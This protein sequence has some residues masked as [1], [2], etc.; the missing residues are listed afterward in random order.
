MS[1]AISRYKKSRVYSPGGNVRS[2]RR[3]SSGFR[4]ILSLVG[5]VFKISAALVVVVGFSIII[6]LGYREVTTSSYLTL[7]KIEVSG[8][9]Q[10]TYKDVLDAAGV[11]LGDNL[12]GLNISDIR[13]RMMKDPWVNSVI[14][15]REFPDKLCLNL[16]ERQACFWIKKDSRL[17]YADKNGEI[18]APVKTQGFVSLPFLSPRED[19]SGLSRMVKSFQRGDMPFSLQQIAWIGFTPANSVVFELRSRDLR[20]EMNTDNW[21]LSAS[22]LGR[23]WD[24]LQARSELD[25]AGYVCAGKDIA[26]VEFKKRTG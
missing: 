5:L 16:T 15:T 24:D 23:I 7:E 11:D 18:I 9:E 19:A 25:G 3:K 12:A 4:D 1:V 8:N 13:S 6:L 2:G 10:L 20:V 22:R 26:W 17:Y 14:V 21:N